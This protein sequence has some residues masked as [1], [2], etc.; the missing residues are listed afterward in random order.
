MALAIGK[1]SCK[2]EGTLLSRTECISEWRAGREAQATTNE[3]VGFLALLACVS[4]S[5]PSSTPSLKAL[6]ALMHLA[7]A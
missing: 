7:G 4:R 5:S 3:V 1:N 6:Y 2:A